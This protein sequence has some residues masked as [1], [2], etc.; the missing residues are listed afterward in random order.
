MPKLGGM[1]EAQDNDGSKRPQGRCPMCGLASDAQYRPFCSKRCANIDLS[2]WLT[3]SYVIP[4]NAN[5]NEGDDVDLPPRRDDA[6][7]DET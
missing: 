4:G 7:D 5:D 2:R 6:D 1:S 3:G